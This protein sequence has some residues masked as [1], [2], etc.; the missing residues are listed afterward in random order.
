[1]EF[2]ENGELGDFLKKYGSLSE[3]RA[4]RWFLQ[5]TKAIFYLHETLFIGFF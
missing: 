4:H 1:M 3:D 2:A 5:T